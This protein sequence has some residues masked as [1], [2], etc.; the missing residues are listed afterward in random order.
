MNFSSLF[1]SAASGFVVAPQAV[2]AEILSLGSRHRGEALVGALAEL[3]GEAL[4][5][6]RSR[7]LRAVVKQLKSDQ[8]ARAK[9]PAA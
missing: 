1:A 2:R 5:T 3:K 6:A 4:P 9:T 8:R 7:L